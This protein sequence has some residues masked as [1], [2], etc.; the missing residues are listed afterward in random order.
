MKFKNIYLLLSLIAAVPVVTIEGN[1]ASVITQQKP[2]NNGVDIDDL[3]NQMIQA[4]AVGSFVA[5]PP[6]PMMVY[7]RKIGMPLL[8]AFVKVRSAFRSGW[9]W[10]MQTFL[11]RWYVRGKQAS[12]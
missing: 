2:S 1:D 12:S 5:K 4:G 6:H 8:Q 7:L 10:L 9:R 3:E 11:F